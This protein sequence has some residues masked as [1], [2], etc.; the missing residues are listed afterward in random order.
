MAYGSKEEK[1]AL[2]L[3]DLEDITFGIGGLLMLNMLEGE[4]DGEIDLLETDAHIREIVG[5]I[6]EV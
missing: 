4:L 3:D 5:V 1:Q 6:V 2:M